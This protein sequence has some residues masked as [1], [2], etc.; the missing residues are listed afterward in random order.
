MKL[1]IQ[2]VKEARVEVE[3]EV[4][5]SI[6]TGFMILVGIEVDD[7][8]EDVEKAA[9]K[10]SG[11]RIFDDLDGKMNLDIHEASGSVLSISQ[12][13]LSADMRKGNRPSFISAMPAV[14]ADALYESFNE[15]LRE[16]GLHVESG[17]F[18][19][20]MNVI[21]NNDGPVTVIMVVKD[22]RVITV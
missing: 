18:Q 20:H 2:K 3:N 4:V 13:T 8:L 16:C 21:L 1:V 6:G 5:G 17:I 14:E 9:K 10:V 7:T 19:T 11:L 15:S 22:G 12:F